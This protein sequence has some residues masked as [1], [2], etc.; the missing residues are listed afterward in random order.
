VGDGQQSAGNLQGGIANLTNAGKGRV[1]GV[2]NKKT[3]ALKDMIMAALKKAGG[4]E[5][6]TAQATESP[7]AFMA[8]VG[9]VL[10]LQLTGKDGG[11]IQHDHRQVEDELDALNRHLAAGVAAGTASSGTGEGETVQ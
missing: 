7:A 9:K 4:V 8:L 2:P 3:A 10:P 1:K 5:Y 11:A 6:L